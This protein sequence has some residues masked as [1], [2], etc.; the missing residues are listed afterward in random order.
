MRTTL[1]VV[2]LCVVFGQIRDVPQALAQE[3]RDHTKE[4]TFET[5]KAGTTAL[6]YFRKGD[7]FSPDG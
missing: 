6:T 7:L 3:E 4:C 5:C 2:V 1:A